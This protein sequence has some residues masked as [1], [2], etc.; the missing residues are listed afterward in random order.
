M[1]RRYATLGRGLLGRLTLGRG[2]DDFTA[3][4]QPSHVAEEDYQAGTGTITLTWTTAQESLEAGDLFVLYL[5]CQ[6][7][8]EPADN[9]GMTDW[10]FLEGRGSGTGTAHVGMALFVHRYDG[11]TLPTIAS[12]PDTGNHSSYSLNTFRGIDRNITLTDLFNIGVTDSTADTTFYSRTIDDADDWDGDVVTGVTAGR[13]YAFIIGTMGADNH[14]GATPSI[15]TTGN[16]WSGTSTIRTSGHTNGSDGTH[17]TTEGLYEYVGTATLQN[18]TSVTNSMR[19]ASIALLM[20]GHAYR[21]MRRETYDSLALSDSATR[22]AAFLRSTTDALSLSDAATRVGAWLRS[23]TDALSLSDVA[24]RSVGHFRQVTDALSLSDVAIRVGAYTRTVTDALGLSDVA[25][26]TGLYVRSTSDA[27]SLSD[28]ATKI[29]NQIR[30]VTDS[31][32]FSNDPKSLI[33]GTW[34]KITTFVEHATEILTWVF[35][36]TEI[37]VYVE[38]ATDIDTSVE[39][40]QSDTEIQTFVESATDIETYV[41]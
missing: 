3:W 11:T 27:L 38:H 10:T 36:A 20:P 22:V 29:L 16:L 40:V 12:L 7:G 2:V 5:E 35:S 34:A 15:T 1:P 8:E 21:V 31:I 37:D 33:S 6:G 17:Q 4:E 25:T 14:G 39:L 19:S 24:T 13:P 23:T 28:A 26:R 41:E 18:Q 9:T 30:S 32:S